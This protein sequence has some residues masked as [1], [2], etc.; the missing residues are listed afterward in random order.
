MADFHAAKLAAIRHIWRTLPAKSGHSLIG[1][2]LNSPET[3]EGPTV[4]S[5]QADTIRNAIHDLRQEDLIK[6]DLTRE[7]AIATL[8]LIEH[9][10]RLLSDTN[11]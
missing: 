4:R 5:I 2:V 6:K 3:N 10:L 9:R 7:D 8:E 1:R 11:P